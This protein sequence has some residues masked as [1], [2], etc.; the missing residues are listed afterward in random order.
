MSWK[1]WAIYGT[2]IPLIA[3]YCYSMKRDYD[4]RGEII[5][6]LNHQIDSINNQL[7]GCSQEQDFLVTKLKRGIEVLETNNGHLQDLL[8]S[9]HQIICDP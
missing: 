1:D 7:L 4:E 3:F 5:T 9:Y 2:C 6:N 8:D